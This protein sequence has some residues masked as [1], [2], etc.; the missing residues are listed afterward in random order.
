MIAS[1]PGTTGEPRTR[2]LTDAELL[3]LGLVA[4]M[5]RH[6]YELEREIER[7][8]M[9]EWT[10]IGFSSVYFVLGKLE[11]SGLVRAARPA[12]AKARKTFTITA[13]GRRALV[14]C[15]RDALGTYRP[16]YPSVLLGMIHWP[17][18]GRE[19]ALDALAARGD[20]IDAELA[21]LADVRLDRQPLPDFVEALFDYSIGQLR[22]EAEWIARTR[23]YMA[24]RPWLEERR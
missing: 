2:E 8:G 23:D 6:G 22:A 3:L 12:A 4:E 21:R 24:T 20:A 19:E 18:L 16:T 14:A 13:A 10:P 9:R 7:R 5:P 11:R 1:E 17:V 15:T